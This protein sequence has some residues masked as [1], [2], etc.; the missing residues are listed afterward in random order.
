MF[1]FYTIRRLSSMLNKLADSYKETLISQKEEMDKE[2]TRARAI[3][4]YM[5]KMFGC[6]N[7]LTGR[8]YIVNQQRPNGVKVKFYPRNAN[9]ILIM[10]DNTEYL[11]FSPL[12]AAEWCADQNINPDDIGCAEYIHED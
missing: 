5:H 12:E 1:Q 2:L 11:F 4:Y 6:I 3:K 9:T 7:Q 8:P 10:Q